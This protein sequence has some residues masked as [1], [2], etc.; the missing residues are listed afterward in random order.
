[1]YSVAKGTIVKT[2]TVI[3]SLTIERLTMKILTK[4]NYVIVYTAEKYLNKSN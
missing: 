2:P 1:M 3:N 4:K